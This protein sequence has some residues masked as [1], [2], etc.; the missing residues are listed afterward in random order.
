MGT[1]LPKKRSSTRWLIDSASSNLFQRPHSNS[2]RHNRWVRT[3]NHR[4]LPPHL[5]QRISNRHS[6]VHLHPKLATPPNL[7]YPSI[8]QQNLA[9]NRPRLNSQTTQI[10]VITYHTRVAAPLMNNLICLNQSLKF[11]ERIN[12]QVISNERWISFLCIESLSFWRE[13]SFLSRIIN[14]SLYWL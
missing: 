14:S 7:P 13:K 10:I 8:N 5:R 12:S 11:L 1:Q 2:W 9:T 4:E 3:I 6:V